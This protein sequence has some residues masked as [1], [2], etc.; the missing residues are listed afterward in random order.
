MNKEREAG[1]NSCKEKFASILNI[2]FDSGQTVVELVAKDVLFYQIR[3][4]LIPSI[5]HFSKI[6]N[7]CK[8]AC[9]K[10]G[11]EFHHS[12]IVLRTYVPYCSDFLSVLCNC[13]S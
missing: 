9:T 7:S 5:K 10:E 12:R 11:K 6:K 8:I 2:D 13:I 1:L 3:W 4:K